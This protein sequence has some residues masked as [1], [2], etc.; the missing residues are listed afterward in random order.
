MAPVKAYYMVLSLIF[1]S[2]YIVPDNM[3]PGERVPQRAQI[4]RSSHRSDQDENA[5]TSWISD[6][7]P[8]EEAFTDQVNSPD[9]KAFIY[10]SSLDE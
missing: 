3:L 8:D 10:H 9:E 5:F 4:R 6:H 1:Y 7:K 2:I